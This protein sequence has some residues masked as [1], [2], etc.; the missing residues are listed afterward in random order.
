MTLHMKGA[1]MKPSIFIIMLTLGV[2]SSLMAEDATRTGAT[3]YA[4]G[5]PKIPLQVTKD[6]KV[7]YQVSDDKLNGSTNRA[8][9]YA[10]KLL[11]TYNG[12]KVPDEA[13]DLHLVFHGSS[14]TALV[15]SAARKSLKAEGGE[16]N[17]NVELIN[18]LLTRGVSIEVCESSMSQ[19]GIKPEDFV[20]SEIATVV[21]AFPRLISLQH[22][23]YAYIKFE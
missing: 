3:R 16:Q 8:L 7:A 5:N 14:L 6:I 1:R 18:E 11:D 13:I 12:Q 22:L 20:S 15:N 9:K 4:S 17:P 2:S 10:K 21:G 19:I 23:G